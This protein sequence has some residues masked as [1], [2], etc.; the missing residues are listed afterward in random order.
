MVLPNLDQPAPDVLAV[1]LGRP[2][3]GM[4]LSQP[5]GQAPHRV[6][7]GPDG[8]LGVA[9]GPQRQL[10]GDGEHGEV[11]MTHADYYRDM[12]RYASSPGG[13]TAASALFSRSA[14]CRALVTAWSR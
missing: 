11:R 4:V 1:Q 3:L 12:E 5:P 9:V 14:S 7:I 2:D 13:T 8:V 6:L 10:P